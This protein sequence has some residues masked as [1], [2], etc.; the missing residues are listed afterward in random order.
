MH[1]PFPQGQSLFVI[2]GFD[3]PT[4][5]HRGI[6][7]FCWDLML[8]GQ[9]QSAS[10]G[11]PFFAAA[12]GTVDFV[13][14][15]NFSGGAGPAN[16]ISIKEADHE[17]CDY[18]HLRQNSA[19][20]TKGAQVAFGT[21]LADVG[22]TGAAQGAFHLHMAVT[23]LGEGN[24]SSGGTFVT[25]PS[26]FLDY[27]AA[28]DQGSTWR[29][30]SKGTSTVGQWIRRPELISP[31]VPGRAYVNAV[32]RSADKLD[33]FLTDSNGVIFTAAWQPE[34]ADWW[35][36]WWE[37]RG[38]R[39]ASGAPVHCVA[40]NLDKV[41]VFV[42]GTDA[43]VYTAAW[44]PA[45]TDWWHGWWGVKGG[46][47]ALSAHV[48]AVSRS[49]DKLD[50]FVVGTDGQVYTAAWEPAFADGWHGW[51]RIGNIQVPQGAPINVVS[52]SQDKLDVF[53]TD[54]NGVVQTAAWEPGFGSRHG[55]WELRG[56]RAAP[57]APVN[58]V[59][60]SRDK[61]DVFVTGTDGRVYTAAWE[62]SF[63]DGWHGWWPIGSIQVP[64]GSPVNA[65]SRSTD[66]LDVFVTD[67]NGVVQT[68]AWEP[69]FTSGHGWWELRSGRAVPG[70]PVTAVS[71][72]RDKLDVFVVGT[73]GRVYTAAWEPTFADGWHGW[74]AMGR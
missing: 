49:A 14:Q 30:V 27:Q 4:G 61:L 57:G 33:V 16:V 44:E 9:P 40:R 65:A 35:H 41:D 63:T 46:R 25:I 55:W 48:T 47:T 62:A 17:F 38:G 71:R 69:G 12:S 66:K 42:S 18:L 7:A 15:D 74:W 2:Q 5:S 45:F 10:N 1:L 73:D 72:S 19:A 24:K 3:D 56:G 43:S 37:L 6:A 32:S 22:D 60:R 8:A 53:V 31:R 54:V 13:K 52:R 34:F 59:S 11:I 20:V 68:A 36:G 29:H 28:D 58:A 70:A 26:A 51:W 21:A 64:Q 39:A 67:T 23:N 50:V